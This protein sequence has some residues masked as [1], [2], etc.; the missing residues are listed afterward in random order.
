MRTP[1]EGEAAEAAKSAAARSTETLRSHQP[2]RLVLVVL[3]FVTGIVDAAS[4]LGLGHIFTANVTGNIVLLGF[5]LAGA[6]QVSIIAS[7]LSLAAFLAG[8]AAGGRL[9]RILEATGNRWVVTVLA[10]ESGLVVV[11]ALLAALPAHVLQ[12]LIVILLAL[13][14]GVRNATVRRLA[15]PDLTTT[16]LTLTL[17]G[18]AADTQFPGGGAPNAA[19]RIAAVLAMIA[20]AFVGALLLR[21]GLIAPLALAAILVLGVT[22]AYVVYERRPPRLA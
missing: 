17:T 13:A 1:G 12:Y 20:G 9:A 4:Y 11:A 10:A 21:I 3:T 16:V 15:V 18:L 14:M 8:A 7:L 6:G 2:L 5:A 22:T 19:R